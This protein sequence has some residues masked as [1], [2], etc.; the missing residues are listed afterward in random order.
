MNQKNRICVA[1]VALMVLAGTVKCVAQN[2]YSKQKDEI[3]KIKRS[4]DSY[5]CAEATCKTIE[6]AQAVAEEMFYQ[7]INEYVASRKKLKGAS[8]IV[9]NDAKTLKN[10]ITMPRGTNMHRVFLYVK[11]SDIIGVNNPVVIPVTTAGN[12]TAGETETVPEDNVPVAP[13]IPETVKELTAAKNVTELGA[14]LKRMKNNG[15]VVSYDKYNNLTTKS[16][17]YLVI[18]DATGAVKAVL[19]D[20]AERVNVVTGQSDSVKNYPK[21]AAIGVKVK[22]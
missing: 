2:D 15:S 5:V 22:K 10:E 8:D 3:T 9:V 4:P 7:N 1:V 11:K 16:E 18:Y 6:E 20:G 12:E 17:W 14:M 13:E 19:T 21:H